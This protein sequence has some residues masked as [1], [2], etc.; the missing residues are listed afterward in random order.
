MPKKV[1]RCA[2]RDQNL[3]GELHKRGQLCHVQS[4]KCERRAQR[5]PNRSI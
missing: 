5:I 3:K 4:N 2:P 1:P